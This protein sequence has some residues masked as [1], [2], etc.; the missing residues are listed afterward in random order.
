MKLKQYD[1]AQN[2]HKAW[3][4]YLRFDVIW[5][6]FGVAD[7]VVYF[8]AVTGLPFLVNDIIDR[9]VGF[10]LMVSGT[11]ALA[12]GKDEQADKARQGPMKQILCQKIKDHLFLF[13]LRRFGYFAVY[14]LPNSLQRC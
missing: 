12:A 7:L 8:V 2:P 13:S 5:R 3:Y 14:P 1:L 9:F 6:W 4:G 11:L 10:G